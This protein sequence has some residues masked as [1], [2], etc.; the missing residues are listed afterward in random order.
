[1]ETIDHA[2]GEE[3]INRLYSKW[4][5]ILYISGGLLELPKCSFYIMSWK[6]DLHGAA[7]LNH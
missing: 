2:S 1:M 6:F 7:T 4:A 3:A 5:N